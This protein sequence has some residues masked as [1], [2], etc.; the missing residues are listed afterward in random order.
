MSRLCEGN[1]ISAVT[2]PPACR[3]VDKVKLAK[4][5]LRGNDVEAHDEEVGRPVEGIGYR[6]N[7]PFPARI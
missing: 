6:S 5:G 7:A 4:V 3:S 2:D 1:S